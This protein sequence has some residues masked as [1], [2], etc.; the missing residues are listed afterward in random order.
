MRVGVID[1]GTNST[2][3]L[4]ADAEAGRVNEVERITAVTRLGEGVDSA[5]SLRDDARERVR[6]C[7]ERYASSIRRLGATRVLII[8]TSSVREARDGSEFISSLAS[9]FGFESRILTGEEEARLSFTGATLGID[10]GLRVALFDV[11]GGSTEVV[12]G[13]DG[14]IEFARSLAI[15]C[16]RLTERFLKSDPADQAEL[17][18]AATF[19]EETL[20]REID[21]GSLIRPELT[22]AVAG[23]ATALAAMDLGLERYDRDKVHGHVITYNRIAELLR[24]LAAMT[25]AQRLDIPAMEKGRADVIV[26]GSLIMERLMRYMGA[27]EVYISELDILDGTALFMERGLI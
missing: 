11:G 16:V 22:I 21:L 19:T 25:V 27:D 23:T 6:D 15:G 26:A 1:T 18:A 20:E 5:S 4:I 10:P 9:G 24:R 8:A 7:V 13:R 17:S 2:R 3:L 14:D 12:T